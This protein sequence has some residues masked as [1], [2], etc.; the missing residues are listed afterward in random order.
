MKKKVYII[1]ACMLMALVCV[2]GLFAGG[3]KDKAAAGGG[4]PKVAIVLK[5][6][7]SPY[8][9]TV[10]KGA[11]EAAAKYGLELVELGP[12]TED[13]VTEQVNMMEDVLSK[14][15]FVGIVFS[16]SQ[17]PTAV[18]VMNKAKAAKIPVAVIDTPMPESY[19]DYLTYIGSNNYQ[20]G[21]LGAQEMVKVLPKGAKVTILEG[22]PGNVAMTDRANGAEKVF[23]DNGFVIESR[24]PANS[25]RERA[26]SI[27]QNVLQKGDIQGVFSAN[28]DQAEGAYRALTQSGKKAVVMGVDG[29]QSAKESV[30]DGG[31]FGTVAQDAAGMGFLGVESI[32]KTL[33]GQPVDKKIDAPTPV[34][35]KDN[36]T[37]YL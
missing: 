13:A 20:I 19:S 35:T 31:L 18:N 3:G 37:Q 27:I 1:A 8:W 7:S 5:T 34:I 16:P 30:R 11:R 24:Q 21:V 6:L 15:E 4:K 28:D 36:V 32:Y 17:P 10:L 23:K 2:N 12:P 26:F 14:G 22:A 9:Q 29:N 33:Q 25:D